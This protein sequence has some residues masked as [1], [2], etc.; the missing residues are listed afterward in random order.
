MRVCAASPNY[1]QV[2]IPATS[3]TP[4]TS[5]TSQS[6]DYIIKHGVLRFQGQEMREGDTISF[7]SEGRLYDKE[8]VD[9]YIH[10]LSL[11]KNKLVN[12]FERAIKESAVDCYLNESANKDKEN[13]Y[14][15]D[16]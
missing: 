6:F 1:R 4:S 3:S 13:K 5:S 16:K 9:E 7:T 2:S 15:C 14:T 11:K 8:T 12:E 10:K